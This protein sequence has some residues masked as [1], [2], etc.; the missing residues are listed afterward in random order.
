M[1]ERT[2]PRT[3]H[4]VLPAT[5]RPLCGHEEENSRQAEATSEMPCPECS[6]VLRS[7]LVWRRPPILG[8]S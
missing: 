6:A 1:N 2:S 4:L 7:G 5:G 8:R 3:V